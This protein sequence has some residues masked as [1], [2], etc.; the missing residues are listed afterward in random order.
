MLGVCYMAD[1][2][3]IKLE[4]KFSNCEEASF[5]AKLQK[6]LVDGTILNLFYQHAIQSILTLSV[7]IHV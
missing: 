6:L 5:L 2:K 4:Q 3:L 7:I 1:N